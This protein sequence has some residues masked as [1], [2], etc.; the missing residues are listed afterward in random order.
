V[1]QIGKGRFTTAWRAVEV[2]LSHLVYLVV[3]QEHD[4]SKQLLSQC[5]GEHIPHLRC[6]GDIGERVLYET[7]YYQPLTAQIKGAWAQYKL[8]REAYDCAMRMFHDRRNRREPL[9]EQ[10]RQANQVFSDQVADATYISDS[11]KDSVESMMTW[12]DN[13]PGYLIEIAKR[14]LAVDCQGRLI[15]LDPCFDA[16]ALQ[17]TQQAHLRRA[18]FAVAR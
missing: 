2:S 13:W 11:L 17:K 9:Q 5:R 16:D 15:L 8:L 4:S 6:L 12:V 10:V 18:R 14:N 1:R 7:T 3:D